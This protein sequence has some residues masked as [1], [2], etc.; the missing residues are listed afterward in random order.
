[1]VA[2]PAQV[3]V[4]VVDVVAAESSGMCEEDVQRLW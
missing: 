4:K 3:T 2:A 1:M